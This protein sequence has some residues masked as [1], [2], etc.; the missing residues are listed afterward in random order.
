MEGAVGIDLGTT[1]SILAATDRSG[2]ITVAD[3]RDGG[4]RLR[5]VVAVGAEG[6]TVGEEA[7][8]GAP[9]DPESC[10]AF[11]KRAMGTDWEVDAGGRSWRPQDLSAEVLRALGDDAAAHLGSK[12][13]RAVL[14]I[15]AYFGDDARRATREA[16]ELAGIEPLALIHEPTAACFAHG[17]RSGTVLVYD[18][19]GGT[20]D[21][22]VIA[23]AEAGAEV[24]ATLGDHRLGG[25]DWDDEMTELIVEAIECDS[26]PR[27]DPSLLA[28]LEERAREA[29]HTL[30][31]LPECAVNVSTADGMRRATVTR[32][33]F[34]SRTAH[35][36]DRTAGIVARVLDDI[37]GATRV[38][39]VLL[40]GGSTRMPLCAE[41][42][43]RE[44]GVA[45]RGGV[46]PDEAVARGAAIAAQ[47]AGG[48]GAIG[49]QAGALARI[50]DV[51]AHALG[52]VVVSA[53][54][55]RYVNQVMIDRNAPIP[56][57]STKSH[58]LELP[59]SGGGTLEVHMLQGEA[60]RPLDNQ[61]LG[62]W[63][64]ERI[65]PDRHGSIEV[66]V[67]YAYD[68]DGVVGVSATV[69]GEPLA[70]PRIDREDRDL[71]WTDEDP[72]SHR[73][74]DLSVALAIDV[75]SSMRG[76]ALTQ[77]KAA[78]TGFVDVLE[79]AGLGERIGL[80][81][82]SSSAKSL[83]SLGTSPKR[84]R[85]AAR[86]LNA[87][88]GTNMAAGLD[89]A[90][91]VLR[92]VGG[93]RV[94]VLLTDGMPNNVEETLRARQQLL[95]AEVEIIARGVDGADLAF[96]ERL[97]TLDGE[98]L[99]LADLAAGFRGIARQLAAGGEGLARR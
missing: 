5:S 45:A 7:V 90:G 61:A 23:Q 95:D 9:L 88:G 44:T 37:G 89:A 54:G 92:E 93:R 15:P 73:Q 40:V 29:K 58:S 12:P 42:L 98:I 39:E 78:L 76:A 3:T 77:A 74:A 71:S 72:R 91:K 52:F 99:D 11:F 33:A 36:F 68:R 67:S 10:F 55:G 69:A 84:V 96:L 87:N 14:T 22:S 64:F 26:D 20:F 60:Q 75:S 82:F 32:Q 57:G 81:S 19:G 8:R 79:E 83:A 56:A 17:A 16:A 80:V 13:E 47:D 27:D 28:E 25:K 53:D 35:L 49:R 59:A 24:L 48:N 2:R 70:E 1:I 31:R 30:S 63:R 21:V 66:E 41:I 50:R 85:K 46:D 43:S 6:V 4:P 97:A 38:D 62:C 86:A 51:T 65:A 18:L 94:V 34:L